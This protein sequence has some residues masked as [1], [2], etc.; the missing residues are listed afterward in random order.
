[1]TGRRPDPSRARDDDPAYAEGVLSRARATPP[2]VPLEG[3]A[4][5]D[6]RAT[7]GAELV[8]RRL[9]QG[10]RQSDLAGLIG[11]AARTISELESGRRAP[12]DRMCRRLAEA[13]E[14]GR[15]P[16]AAA[17]TEVELIRAAGP[18]LVVFARRRPPR[19]RR[20]RETE[21]ARR[22]IDATIAAERAR[23][24]AATAKFADLFEGELRAQARRGP[25]GSAA[26]AF[27]DRW[28]R[29]PPRRGC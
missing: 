6:L 24:A 12:S 2:R 19:L 4:R 11:G 7:F 16:V 28:P 3:H 21:E 9:A 20:A 29:V 17:R 13:L 26:E 1:M 5:D 14:R 22:E 25:V 18:A 23:R 10:L 8:R 27:P 15:D